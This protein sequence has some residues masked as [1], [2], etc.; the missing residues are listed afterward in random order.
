MIRINKK[1]ECIENMEGSKVNET[2]LLSL[3]MQ[4][5]ADSFHLYPDFV[6]V[7]IH[8]MN[9]I[10][11]KRGCYSTPS[12]PCIRHCISQENQVCESGKG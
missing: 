8:N 1:V 4:L 10:T 11:M 12:T 3:Y 2:C 6:D 5:L 9:I 7:F